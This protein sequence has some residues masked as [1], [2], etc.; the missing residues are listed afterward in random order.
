LSRSIT[1]ARQIGLRRFLEQLA[2]KANYDGTSDA[3]PASTTE[4]D[5]LLDSIDSELTSP[6][7]MDASTTPDLIVS[8]GAALIVNSEN[9][10]SRSIPHIGSLLPNDFASGTITFPATSGNPIVVSPGNNGTLTV[11]SNNYIKVLIYLDANG[12]L[13]VLPGIENASEA[14]AS[15]LPSPT[16]T[17]PLGYIT[18]F[19]NAGTVDAIVQAKVIQF[20]VGGGGGGGTGDA[21][22]FTETLKNRLNDSIFE[23]VTPYI[24]EISTDDATHI[25]ASSTGAY[26][27]VSSR[28]KLAAI[29][30]SLV[31]ANILDATFLAGENNIGKAEV[32]LKYDDL[33]V[34]TNAIYELS[35]SGLANLGDVT[36]ADI[37]FV[38][39]AGFIISPT[40]YTCQ[41]VFFDSS[42]IIKFVTIDAEK[43]GADT[44]DITMSIYSL[45]QV[46]LEPIAI[47]ATSDIETYTSLPASYGEVTFTFTGGESFN[48]GTYYGIVLNSTAT[49]EFVHVGVDSSV[50][51]PGLNKY[52]TNNSGS[53]WA[54]VPNDRSF[55]R[56]K[57]VLDISPFKPFTMERI[58]NTNTFR[59][60]HEFELEGSNLNLQN[61]SV[62]DSLVIFGGV[63]SKKIS[64]EFVASNLSIIRNITFDITTIIG[65]PQGNIFISIVKDAAGLPSTDANDIIAES[66]PINVTTL[67]VGTLSAA[68]NATVVAGT[69]HIVMT[70]DQA[71]LDSFVTSTHEFA[72]GLEI[73]G[74]GDSIYNGTIWS[75]Q[76]TAFTGVVEGIE[77][78]LRLK[79]TSSITDAFIEGYGVLYEENIGNLAFSTIVD[80]ITKSSFNAVADN[81]NEFALPFTPNSD[82][83]IVHLL[84][85]GQSFRY[86]DFSLQGNTVVFPVDQFNNG[87]IE[88]VQ[89][90]VFDQVRGGAFDNSDVNANLLANNHL[91]SSDGT[92]D[93]SVAGRGIF[94]RRPDG[95][96]VE[97]T[98]DDANNIAIYSV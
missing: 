86:G 51:Q 35:R 57:V 18:L 93:K 36:I 77:L 83:L 75:P 64:R 91:G 95:T 38:D 33:G 53:T 3:K 17:L 96:L 26:D 25:D 72:V 70:P 63:N 13:N 50:P 58:D 19:N 30:D 59:G 54:V 60:I 7:R 45:D 15:V 73:A 24:A 1:D 84:G 55:S 4:L 82:L 90:L 80:G 88:K 5:N 81:S 43:T 65:N 71:Y 52:Y 49:P 92:F 56:Q 41:P 74:D 44:G 32:I 78:D 9:N 14:A 76:N 28:Y 97:L 22:S 79:V 16:N 21:N 87:G 61:N 20:G 98:I 46:T 27:L 47:M 39:N 23:A 29:A 37:D 48:S 2:N 8:I 89:T 66:A 10:R 42:G 68:F 34:D 12:D 40:N 67:S 85:S 94:L 69:Y 11:T 62:Q 6:L 31:S